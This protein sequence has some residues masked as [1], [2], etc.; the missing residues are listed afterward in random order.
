VAAVW[1]SLALIFLAGFA[2]GAAGAWWTM[3]R[4]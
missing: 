2:I 3:T 1:L 4:R